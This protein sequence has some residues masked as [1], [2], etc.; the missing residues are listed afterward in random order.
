MKS[1]YVLF[2]LDIFSLSSA[3]EASLTACRIWHSNIYCLCSNTIAL[4]VLK[5]VFF[6]TPIASRTL[7][8]TQFNRLI[9]YQRTT[10]SPQAGHSRVLS[11][12]F[13][14]AKLSAERVADPYRVAEH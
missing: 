8:P 10:G 11:E 7:F 9:N 14:S 12:T 2:I 1:N 5:L 6:E 13:H 3:A 4:I